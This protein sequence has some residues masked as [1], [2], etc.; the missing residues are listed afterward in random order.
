MSAARVLS[1]YL[2]RLWRLLRLDN[3][4]YIAML[5]YLGLVIQLAIAFYWT[6][7]EF[8]LAGDVEL[9]CV[10]I[11]RSPVISCCRGL[12]RGWFRIRSEV[13]LEDILASLNGD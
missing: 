8:D 7:Y 6:L 12:P 4:L 11:V 9:I 2:L 13:L 5:D 1:Y 10:V 3:G